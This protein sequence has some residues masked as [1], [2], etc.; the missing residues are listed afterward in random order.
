MLTTKYMQSYI[1]FS[2]WWFEARNFMKDITLQSKLK[3]ATKTRNVKHDIIFNIMVKIKQDNFRLCMNSN[4]IEVL[5]I[6]VFIA[7]AQKLHEHEKVYSSIKTEECVTS[8]EL[9]NRYIKQDN[10]LVVDLFITKC[11]Y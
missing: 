5:D 11:T 2:D 9:W 4:N 8:V 7:I 1:T 6:N 10:Q 3:K